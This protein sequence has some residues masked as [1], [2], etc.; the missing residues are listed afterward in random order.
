M[1][2]V[3]E[4]IDFSYEN[5]LCLHKSPLSFSSFDVDCKISTT[6]HLALGSA[7]ASKVRTK[8]KQKLLTIR[9]GMIS[10]TGDD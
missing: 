4:A 3:I 10:L 5:L 2:L 7:L 9:L 1:F 6:R 8:E